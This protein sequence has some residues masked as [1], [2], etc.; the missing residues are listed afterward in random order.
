MASSCGSGAS[1]RKRKRD[2]K[3]KAANSQ[4]G[5]L[6]ADASLRVECGHDR[7]EEQSRAGNER[8][9]HEIVS[10]QLQDSVAAS[11]N[12]V[13]QTEPKSRTTEDFLTQYSKSSS[14]CR[15][16]S[17]L[18]TKPP[19]PCL[20]NSKGDAKEVATAQVYNPSAEH[21]NS[22]ATNHSTFEQELNWCIGQLELGLVRPN[23][24]KRQ[25]E[26]NERHIKILSSSK[27]HLPR[28]RQIM[29]NLFGDYR[30]KMKTQPLPD[31][32]QSM[33]KPE[34]GSVEKETMEAT[35]VFYKLSSV[36]A[37]KS[38]RTELTSTNPKS[39]RSTTGLGLEGN[40]FQFNFQINS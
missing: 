27:T 13:V 28:K 11:E 39:L 32:F 8:E 40:E 36:Q 34:I 29:K 12:G 22:A 35:G 10:S 3:K 23:A 7:L 2:K 6:I 25:K 30:A 16:S 1:K 19:V 21:Q 24:T 31:R 26:D 20:P 33:K 4:D 9:N 18:N 14:P 38:K 15:S 37:H 17:I 5:S